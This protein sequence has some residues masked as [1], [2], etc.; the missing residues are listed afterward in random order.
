M[1][2]KPKT[3]DEALGALKEARRGNADRRRRISTL[4][5]L[6]SRLA[7]RCHGVSGDLDALE[8]GSI[9]TLDGQKTANDTADELDSLAKRL[10][11]AIKEAG[12]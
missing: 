3:L 6:I 8:V 7:L 10:R 4:E 11:A 5:A 12:Q 2:Y 9:S 1:T